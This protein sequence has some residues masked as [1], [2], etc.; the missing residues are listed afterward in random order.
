[1]SHV[2]R[3]SMMCTIGLM[4]VYSAY[5]EITSPLLG[6]NPP[7]GMHPM[8]GR[9]PMSRMPPMLAMHPMSRM[10]A[11]QM[12]YRINSQNNPLA[13]HLLQKCVPF[14]SI[15]FHYITFKITAMSAA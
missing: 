1:M 13:S 7:S 8:S 9:H 10:P 12:G 5:Q 3:T 15:R 14:G 4:Y 11:H 6:M 2:F